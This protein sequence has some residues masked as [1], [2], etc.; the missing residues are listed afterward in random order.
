MPINLLRL[1]QRP[2]QTLQHFTTTTS[3]LLCGSVSSCGCVVATGGLVLFFT[4]VVTVVVPKFQSLF[5][6]IH[7][8]YHRIAGGVL[9]IW[10]LIG[11]VTVVTYHIGPQSLHTP[12]LLHDDG[13]TTTNNNVEEWQPPPPPFLER[14]HF[15]KWNFA[16]DVVLGILGILATWTAAIDFP[17]RYV[18]NQP[19]Q[20]GTLSERTIVTQA[21]MIEHLFY[22]FLNLVQA[23]YLHFLA[24]EWAQPMFNKR[25]IRWIALFLVTSPWLV[26]GCFPVHSFHQNWKL[27]TKE[28]QSNSHELLLYKIKKAQYL[29]Y[30]HV[31]L[32]G[33]N[34]SIILTAKDQSLVHTLAWRV[35][36][37]CLNT[38]YVMEFFLQTLVKRHV[39]TQ[40]TMLSLNRLLMLVSTVAAIHSIW[41]V[42][43]WDLSLM[44]FL[45]NW[46]NRK[47]DLINVMFIG[48]LAMIATIIEQ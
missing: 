8:R 42:V 39:M 36:W 40:F 26:R 25:L 37:I 12:R 7:G 17:H 45:L 10:L 30:K 16:Y 2:V 47:H 38:S 14:N 31:I 18:S 1:L 32:N 35:F 48:T 13:T 5:G 9:L 33:I 21:E 6:D 3:I 46:I 29:F 41:R 23:L 44:S 11:C 34:L 4:I 28:K 22:Q 43:R 20:S 24:S 19:G 27:S 15:Q